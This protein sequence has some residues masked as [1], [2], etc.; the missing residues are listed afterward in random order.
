MQAGE[1]LEVVPRFTLSGAAQPNG[2]FPRHQG[3]D[4][5]ACYLRTAVALVARPAV[6]GLDY[7]SCSDCAC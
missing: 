2:R 7:A 1:P 3:K 5:S 6:D 4:R